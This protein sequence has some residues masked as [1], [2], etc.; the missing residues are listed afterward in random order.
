M[1][2]K[3]LRTLGLDA[4]KTLN[5][6]NPAFMEEIFHRTKW[7]THRPNNI[8]VYVHKTVKYGDKSLGTLGPYIWNSIQE[9]M[10]AETNFIN[11]REYIN[12]LVGPTYKRNLCV[13]ISSIKWSVLAHLKSQPRGQNFQAQE[14][15]E[16][17]SPHQIRVNKNTKNTFKIN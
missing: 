13:Y 4:F 6:L 7:L 12:Q 1:E 16:R 11:F 17:S 15:V 9:H 8:L 10:K 14:P 5:N 2:V 3:R